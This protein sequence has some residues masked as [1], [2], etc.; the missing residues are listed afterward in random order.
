MGATASRVIAGRAGAGAASGARRTGVRAAVAGGGAAG[1]V[2]P[3]GPAAPAAWAYR[4]TARGA[5]A[6]NACVY[7]ASPAG[8]STSVSKSPSPDCA[9]HVSPP[10]NDCPAQYDAAAPAGAPGTHVGSPGLYPAAISPH[11]SDVE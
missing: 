2:A 1:A 8:H 4:G 7:R 11:C 5:G 9:N 6:A 10:P 3:T